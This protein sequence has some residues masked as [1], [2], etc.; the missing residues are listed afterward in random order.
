M[1]GQ[2]QRWRECAGQSRFDSCLL[3]RARLTATE[4]A[5]SALWAQVNVGERQAGR[6]RL[7]QCRSSK[8]W[9]LAFGVRIGLCPDVHLAAATR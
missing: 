7:S 8:P 5:V 3:S 9:G 1:L 2:A 6:P 4:N